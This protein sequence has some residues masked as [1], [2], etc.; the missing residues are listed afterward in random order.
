[1]VLAQT[2]MKSEEWLIGCP[3]RTGTPRPAPL[4][5]RRLDRPPHRIKWLSVVEQTILLVIAVRLALGIWF[6]Y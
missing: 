6:G 5:P 1:M 3:M 2:F 4:G